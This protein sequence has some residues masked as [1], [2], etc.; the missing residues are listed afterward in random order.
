[1]RIEADREDQ[2]AD[3]RLAGLHRAGEGEAGGRRQNA[4]GKR[5]A[6]QQIGG[7]QRE[8]AAP[9]VDHGGGDVGRLHVVHCATPL[10]GGSPDLHRQQ[11]RPWSSHAAKQQEY[12]A[13]TGVIDII[14][15]F[16]SH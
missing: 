2:R 5:A 3:Q 10:S 16:W 8:L 9:G 7:R 14:M 4:A 11:S 1:M 13:S 15:G 6:D 12:R